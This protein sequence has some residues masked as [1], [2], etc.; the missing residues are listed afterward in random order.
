MLFPVRLAYN[1]TAGDRRISGVTDRRMNKRR[2]AFVDLTEFQGPR[3]AFFA[4][5]PRG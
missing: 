5:C 4:G 3:P 2:V 1:R